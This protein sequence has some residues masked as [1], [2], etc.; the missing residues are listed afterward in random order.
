MHTKKRRE[1]I[2]EVFPAS[3]SPFFFFFFFFF[4]LCPQSGRCLP[5]QPSTVVLGVRP[6]SIFVDSKDLLPDVAIMNLSR[7]PCFES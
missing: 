3:A 6:Q 4:F 5:R 1:S 7:T 2:R